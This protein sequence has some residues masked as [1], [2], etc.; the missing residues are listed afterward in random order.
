M[1]KHTKKEK[2]GI[3]HVKNLYILNQ[4]NSKDILTLLP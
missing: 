3:L 2:L 4:S 1:L